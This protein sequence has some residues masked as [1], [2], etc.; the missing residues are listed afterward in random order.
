MVRMNVGDVV[1][2]EVFF[3]ALDVDESGHVSIEEILLIGNVVNAPFVFWPPDRFCQAA[4]AAPQ[5]KAFTREQFLRWF[6]VVRPTWIVDAEQHRKLIDT[7]QEARARADP[8]NL[9]VFEQAFTIRPSASSSRA[10]TVAGYHRSL[11]QKISRRDP[12]GRTVWPSYWPLAREDL[13][14]RIVGR[15]RCGELYNLR[16]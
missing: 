12:V 13:G 16:A 9:E 5:A 2:G 8:Y 11:S 4:G 14:K 1:Q 7:G 15:R 3:E 10:M 6:A